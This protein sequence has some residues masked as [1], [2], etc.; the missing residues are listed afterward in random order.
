MPLLTGNIYWDTLNKSPFSKELANDDYNLDRGYARRHMFIDDQ[1]KIWLKRIDIL[2]QD[3]T[4]TGGLRIEADNLET[5]SITTDKIKDRNVITTSLSRHLTDPA[6]AAVR[7]ENIHPDA[8]GTIHIGPEAVDSDEIATDAIIDRHVESNTLSGAKIKIDTLPGDRITQTSTTGVI[9]IDNTIDG[10]KILSDSIPQGKLEA[11]AVVGTNIEINAV[12]ASHIN[13]G[14]VAN[15]H[16]ED[17]KIES[18]KL[19]TSGF[20][21]NESGQASP[22]GNPGGGYLYMDAAGQDLGVHQNP[23][24]HFDDDDIPA[25][26]TVGLSE[27][28]ILTEIQKPGISG[29]SYNGATE[30]FSVG[31]NAR[32]NHNGLVIR[33]INKIDSHPSFIQLGPFEATAS[34]QIQS[35]NTGNNTLAAVVNKS[36]L[37]ADQF[38]V[39]GGD[40]HFEMAVPCGSGKNYNHRAV[41][42]AHCPDRNFVY[43]DGTDAKV[44]GGTAVYNGIAGD[45]NNAPSY[46]SQWMQFV[47]QGDVE[48]DGVT[49]YYPIAFGSNATPSEVSKISAKFHFPHGPNRLYLATQLVHAQTYDPSVGDNIIG[50][51]DIKIEKVDQSGLRFGFITG[52]A[53]HQVTG[54]PQGSSSDWA[55]DG[56]HV[57]ARGIIN[58]ITGWDSNR[59][60]YMKVDL[61]AGT[62]LSGDSGLGDEAGGIYTDMPVG[63]DWASRTCKAI[64]AGP[65]TLF[66]GGGYPTVGNWGLPMNS[67]SD[68]HAPLSGGWITGS[69]EQ[70]TNIMVEEVLGPQFAP[71]TGGAFGEQN[72]VCCCADDASLVIVGVSESE[73]QSMI[74]NWSPDGSTAAGDVTKHY[75]GADE[76][77]WYAPDADGNLETFAA[78]GNCYPS[79]WNGQPLGPVGG[80]HDTYSGPN[81]TLPKHGAEGGCYIV[82]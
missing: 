14:E 44:S 70:Y 53:I 50:Q 78:Q 55:T 59:E 26:S 36:R 8:I 32:T 64:L 11:N 30:A 82:T 7:S 22:F 33:K 62:F 41:L 19:K 2:G 71:S 35:Y 24:G 1:S 57:R 65:V 39:E 69:Y 81:Q 15:Y 43:P 23:F 61:Y 56:T 29:G 6:G 5:N 12:R 34:M 79:V 73:C 54:E 20:F 58:S 77:L 4:T 17:D 3:I 76:I 80:K 38:Y 18:T 75:I 25:G 66:A 13:A 67:I 47:P 31:S 46:P 49:G 72:G 60:L 52:A 45:D 27:K 40:Y 21:S 10:D 68:P 63:R 28:A 51:Q 16:L 37:T 74:T 9:F 48:V 42:L